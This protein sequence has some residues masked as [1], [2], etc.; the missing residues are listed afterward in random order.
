MKWIFFSSK[1]NQDFKRITSFTTCADEVN[2]YNCTC[3][4]GYFGR[5][6]SQGMILHIIFSSISF[7]RLRL[8][9]RECLNILFFTP[10]WMSQPFHSHVEY[11]SLHVIEYFISHLCTQIEAA[12][13]RCSN[14]I[15]MF[16][17][18]QLLWSWTLRE[19]CNLYCWS[20]WL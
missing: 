15:C 12:N 6:C 9:S 11:P 7:Y 5:S 16:F 3:M 13:L 19:R 4:T 1:R 8:H 10:E 18:C 14:L 2:D 17:R 20:R